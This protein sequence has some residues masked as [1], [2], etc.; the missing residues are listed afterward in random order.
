MPRTAAC[1]C[2]EASIAVDG[3]LKIHAVCHCS[4]C[5]RRTG[6]AFGWSAYF[7]REALRRTGGEFV[8]YAMTNPRDGFDQQRYFCARCGSTLYW[9]DAKFPALVGV[10]A[11]CLDEPPG[12]PTLSATHAK[13]CAWVA[14]PDTWRT[15]AD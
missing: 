9:H 13:K 12:E 10:A 8:E 1:V 4:N 15:L 6:S 3:P 11:G 5:R 2:G 14:L 7:P